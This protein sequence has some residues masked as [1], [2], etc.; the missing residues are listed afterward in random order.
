MATIRGIAEHDLVIEP[1]LN[2]RLAAM[3]EPL[4]R[5]L[6]VLEAMAQQKPSGNG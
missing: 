3:Q 5:R 1:V 6:D 4:E 2:T